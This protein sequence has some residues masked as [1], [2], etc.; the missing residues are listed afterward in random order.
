MKSG[1]VGEGGMIPIPAIHPPAS[2]THWTMDDEYEDHETAVSKSQRKRDMTA[3]QDLGADLVS[4]PASQLETFDLPDNLRAAILE[5]RR[6]TSHGALRRQMQYIGKLMRTVESE[7]IAARLAAIRGESLAAKAEFHAL[8]RWRDRLLADD[9]A[10][11]DWLAAH[12]GSDAQQLRQLIRNARRE[13]AESKPP[14]AARALFRY[15]R[16]TGAA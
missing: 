10:L 14:K 12:P 3:L 15:L 13:A 9:D 5:A 8:E 2:P 16:D 6:L 1:W 11:T 7:P 4:L